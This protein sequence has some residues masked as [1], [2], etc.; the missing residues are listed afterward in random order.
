MTAE[1][2]ARIVLIMIAEPR[3]RLV[4]CEAEP[5]LGLQILSA[6]DAFMG[7]VH[8]WYDLERCKF[9]TFV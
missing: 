4:C 3:V 6:G 9:S 5:I 8:A 1:S 2:V 7:G